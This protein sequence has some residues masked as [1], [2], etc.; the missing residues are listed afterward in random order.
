MILVLVTR[1]GIMGRLRP[2]SRRAQQWLK[3]LARAVL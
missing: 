2:A 3:K 1:A